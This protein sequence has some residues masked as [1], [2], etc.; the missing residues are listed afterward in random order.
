MERC[1]NSHIYYTKVRTPGETAVKKDEESHAEQTRIGRY[2]IVAMWVVGLGLGTL[3][4]NRSLERQRNPNNQVVTTIDGDKRSITLQRGRYGHYVVTGSINSAE[5][6][7]LVDTGATSVSVPVEFADRA[8]LSRGEQIS[9]RTANGIG[10]AFKTRIDTLRIGDLEIRN[11]TAHINP[12]LSDE[13]LLGMSVLQ[14]FE[15]I[16]RGDQLTIREP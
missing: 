7:F 1:P 15:L 3:L 4:V 6:D 11:A 10:I 16:Q 8:G 2:M 13:V 9:V 12:G 14:N 5:V